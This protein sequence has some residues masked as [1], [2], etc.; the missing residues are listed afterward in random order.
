M[1]LIPIFMPKPKISTYNYSEVERE[2]IIFKRAAVLSVLNQN[3]NLTMQEIA[4]KTNQDIKSTEAI[5]T[6]LKKHGK[7]ESIYINHK[8]LWRRN[9]LSSCG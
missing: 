2:K 1:I 4:K 3:N 7:I 8:K 9:D 6:V 5:L